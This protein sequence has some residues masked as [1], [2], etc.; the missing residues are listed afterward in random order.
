ML[1]AG[2]VGATKTLLGLFEPAMDRPV[3]I[4]VARFDTLAFA[5]LETLVAQFLDRCAHRSRIAAACFGVA[6]PV[7]RQR[8]VLTN[9]PWCVDG[10]ALAAR[11]ALRRVQLLNDLEAMG[12]AVPVLRSDEW[13][14]LQVG[15]AVEDGNAALI[16]A[17]TGLG[18][19]MLHRVDGRLVP[20]ASE[21]GHADF[22]PRTPREFE[23]A[24]A[25]LARYGRVQVEHVVSGPGL[26]NIHEFVHRGTCPAVDARSA[27]P[28]EVPARISE[29]ALTKRCAKCVESLELFVEAY[30]SEAGNLALRAVATAGLYIAGGIA[31]AVLPALQDG[32]FVAAFSAKPPLADLLAAI[33]IR[34]IRLPEVGLLGAAVY[35]AR[36]AAEEFG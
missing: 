20:L 34:V 27:S 18:E 7:R 2:D 14:V 12:Y 15:E 25:L 21:G 36:L 22:A 3:P 1:L 19:A 31:Q 11:L 35:A 5:D 23:L 16:A 24:R 33:P 28:A 26:V 17:G 32:R 13:L 4:E 9:V 29:A 10:P 8:A 30:G 6:G